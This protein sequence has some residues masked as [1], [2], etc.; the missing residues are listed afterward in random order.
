MG[1]SWLG[2]Y[3]RLSSQEVVSFPRS[4][5]SNSLTNKSLIGSPE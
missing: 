3:Y 4:I 5:M 2:N 1:D